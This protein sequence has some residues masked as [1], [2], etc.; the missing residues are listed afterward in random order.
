MAQPAGPF[1][2][3][4][5][6]TGRFLCYCGPDGTVY[7][8]DAMEVWAG[9][10]GG[11]PALGFRCPPEELGAMLSPEK[12]AARSQ[13]LFLPGRHCQGHLPCSCNLLSSPSWRLLV[14]YPCALL[15][16]LECPQ[17]WLLAATH[18]PGALPGKAGA[19]LSV[20]A[21]RVSGMLRSKAGHCQP[22]KEGRLCCASRLEAVVD[23]WLLLGEE[24]MSGPF[25][26]SVAC[27]SCQAGLLEAPPGHGGTGRAA[28]APR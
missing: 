14:L 11:C 9:E 22:Q 13:Q 12:N 21:L 16:T 24:A 20:V 8:T 25:L 18:C 28:R 5:T 27:W 26:P 3:L 6:R 17:L 2:V 15:D 4:R 10:L 1:H 19:G 23:P 7:V